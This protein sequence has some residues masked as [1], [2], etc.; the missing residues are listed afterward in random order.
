MSDKPKRRQPLSHNID[1]LA[2][3]I[4]SPAPASRPEPELSPEQK[5]IRARRPKRATYDI[6][7]E[8][9]ELIAELAIDYGLPQ[10]QIVAALL[11]EGVEALATGK[12][13]LEPRERSE[14]PKFAY[15]LDLSAWLDRL[16][17]LT[18]SRKGGKG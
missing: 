3:R 18:R 13:E 16:D 4:T 14:S 17:S 2:S 7:P 6:P 5:R 12:I 10:S 9:K 8:L 15:N 11:I 1:D